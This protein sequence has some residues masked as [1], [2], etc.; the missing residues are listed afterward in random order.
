MIEFDLYFN[1]N[2]NIAQPLFT[3][4]KKVWAQEHLVRD[5]L[6]IKFFNLDL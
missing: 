2:F 3:Y 1:E 5:N 6:Q 4:D